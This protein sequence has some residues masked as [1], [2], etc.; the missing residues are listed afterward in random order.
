MRGAAEDLEGQRLVHPARAFGQETLMF[1]LRIRNPP[2]RSSEAH[3]HAR[4][5][6]LLGPGK[7]G[8]LERQKGGRDGK[9]CVAV[10]TLQPV[11]RKERGGIPIAD[12]PTAMRFI[13]AGVEGSD[14]VDPAACRT[15]TIPKGIL[16]DPCAGDRADSSDDDAPFARRLRRTRVGYHYRCTISVRFAVRFRASIA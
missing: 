14:P 5:R 6:I 12:F 2:E 11:R 16:S 13:G 10:E 15:N 4:L 8:V 9:L 1:R 7:L 3:A